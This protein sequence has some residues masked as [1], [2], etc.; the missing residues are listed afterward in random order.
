MRSVPEWIG[1]TDDTPIPPRVE[2]RV[3]ER[4][5]GR[6]QCGCNRK[7]ATGEA[8]QCDHIIALTNGGEHRERNLQ[9]LLV[10]HHKTKTRADVA[11]KRKIT[12]VRYRHYGR[13]RSQRPMPG[14]RDSPWKRK[15][16]GKIV[17]R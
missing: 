17:P 4:Y 16:G 12:Q 5:D 2:L 13:S 3:F 10:E 15:I 7:I 14:G 11:V 6:C 8:W 9:P 1:K